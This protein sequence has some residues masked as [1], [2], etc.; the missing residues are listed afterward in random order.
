MGVTWA[1]A[2]TFCCLLVG[3]LIITGLLYLVLPY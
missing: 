1:A 2:S 3:V